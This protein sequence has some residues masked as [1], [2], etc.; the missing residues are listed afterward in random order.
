MRLHWQGDA[1]LH[2]ASL[3]VKRSKTRFT[4]RCWVQQHFRREWFVTLRCMSKDDMLFDFSLRRFTSAKTAQH[5]AESMLQSAMD[6]YS[7]EV[8]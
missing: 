4:V 6:L 2:L 3:A 8:A 7:L 1:H 5:G